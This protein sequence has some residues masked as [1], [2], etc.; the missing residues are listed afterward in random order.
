MDVKSVFLYGRIDEEVYVCQPPGFEDPRFPNHV[1]KLDKAL[2]GL[3]QAPRK[4]YETLSSFLLANHFKRG[5]IDKTLFFKKSNQHI[6]L[7]QIY[8]YDIIFG[9]TDESL[10]KEFESLMKSKFEMS[11]MGELTFFLGLQLKQTPT[12]IFISQSKYVK[13]ILER[14]KLTDCKALGTPMSK[15]TSLSPDL[16][17]ED[18]DQHQYR[19]I[20]GSLMY[21]TASRPNIMFATCLCARFQANPK[22]SHMLAVKRIFRYLK[23]APDL[24]LCKKSISGGC[25]FLGSRIV[26]WQ[27]KK[28][29]C[30]STSTAEA[31]YIAASSCCA[32]VIWIQNQMKDYGVELFNTPIQIDNSSAISITNNPIKH[33]NTKH[34]DIKYHFIRDCEE[35]KL[36]HLVKVDTEHNLAD[37]FTKS[38]DEGRFRCHTS[39]DNFPSEVLNFRYIITSEAK[40]SETFIQKKVSS[41]EQFK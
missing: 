8:V 23:G 21:L 6:M 40:S 20:I 2:Y 19:A 35:K 30:V 31:E 13:D 29:S 27:C 15:T 28:Q 16:E 36:T 38:F 7:A 10:C 33:S 5:T 32:Q 25:Q 17:G 22:A 1:C 11:S 12:G 41:E 3:H 37:L 34:I 4:W 26:S 9:S 14:F 24:G 39:E 18:I